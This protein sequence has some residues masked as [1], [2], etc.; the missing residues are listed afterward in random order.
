MDVQH[1][2]RPRKPRRFRRRR[3]RNDQS[4]EDSTPSQPRHDAFA[5]LRIVEENAEKE[6]GGGEECELHV[7]EHRTDSRGVAVTLRVETTSEFEATKDKSYK[8]ALLLFRMYNMHDPKR[9]MSTSL[10]IR[11]SLSSTGRIY[12]PAPPMCLFH[13]RA[14]LE[15]YAAQASDPIARSHIELCLSYMRRALRQ[16]M[17]LFEI[18]MVQSKEPSIE[19]QHLWMAFKPGTLLYE[20]IANVETVARLRDISSTKDAQE[21]VVN[22]VLMTEYVFYNG[23]DMGY[24]ERTISIGKYD[25]CKQ[26]RELQAFP[27]DLHPDRE[28]IRRDLV[29]RGEKCLSLLGRHHRS[30]DGIAEFENNLDSYVQHRIIVDDKGYYSTDCKEPQF[31]AAT[32]LIDIASNQHMSLGEEELLLFHYQIGGFDLA[33]RKWALFNIDHIQDVQ[34]NSDAFQ[35]L[36]LSPEKKRLIQSLVQQR[37]SKDGGFDDLIKGKGKGLIFLLHGP[38]GVGKTFTA[39]SIAD[40]TKRPLFRISSD[41]LMG[42]ATS[43][44]LRLPGLLSLAKDWEALVLI[45]EADVFMQERRIKDLERNSLVSILLR[46]L[47]Y[48]E[49]IMLLTT[50]RVETIDSAFHSRIHLSL[51][52]PPLSPEALRTLWKNTISRASSNPN[53]RW[54]SKRFLS[55][56]A[57]SQINGRDIKN[58]VSMAYAV[59]KNEKREMR[60]ADIRQGLDALQSFKTDFRQG[61][62]RQRIED[63][64]QAISDARSAPVGV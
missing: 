49:G 35:Q 54:L 62:T 3:R 14:E 17:S 20:K 16:E 19:H 29:R 60:A 22:W 28:R 4:A 23:Q 27:L 13:Y 15:N 32:P 56:L 21:L 45:D 33:W 34:F 5:A 53:P 9:L 57:G 2:G 36:V 8:A 1:H 46:A 26:L 48:F 43:V 64:A 63:G 50:N 7:Y 47:E 12:I 39:E 61:V 18:S 51:A 10:E 59:A 41:Q 24:T 44:E 30:Y 58:I 55:Q 42:D 40:H 6:D 31:I 25:G 38:P 52:Y 11:L 37:N